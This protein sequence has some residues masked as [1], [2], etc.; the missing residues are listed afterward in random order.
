MLIIFLCTPLHNQYQ[1]QYFFLPEMIWCLFDKCVF[2]EHNIA[3]IN[4]PKLSLLNHCWH[5]L[6]SGGV[7][8]STGDNYWSTMS[9][10]NPCCHLPIRRCQLLIRR[11]NKMLK[12]DPKKVP[13]QNFILLVHISTSS[14][15]C[16]LSV[17]EYIHIIIKSA[18]QKTRRKDIY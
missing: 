11:K 18:T 15:V 16:T 2:C 8:K 17:K 3:G 4:G 1:Y 14:G 6:I 12:T 9:F 5:L 10:T 13:C 7:Y